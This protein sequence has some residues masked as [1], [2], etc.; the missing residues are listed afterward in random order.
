M[1][2]RADPLL[3][4]VCALGITQITAWGTSYYSLGVLA[5]PIAADTGWSRSLIYFGFTVSLLVMGAVREVL[6]SGSFLGFPL[7][8]KSYEPWVFMIL[9]PGGFLTL[10]CLMLAKSWWH[11]RRER[12]QKPEARKEAA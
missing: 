11:A 8:G 6:G 12:A 9:P 3:F 7:F 1:T 2:R 5:N 10:G 4:A